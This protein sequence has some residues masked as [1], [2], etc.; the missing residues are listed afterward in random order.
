MRSYLQFEGSLTTASPNPDQQRRI[1]AL[2]QTTLANAKTIFDNVPDGTERATIINN[3]HVVWLQ[4]VNL[5]CTAETAHGAG[6]V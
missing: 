1:V 6:G 2:R 4:G 3:L 5:I